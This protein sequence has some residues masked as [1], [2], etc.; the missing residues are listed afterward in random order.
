MKRSKDC[1][2]SVEYILLFALY[3]MQYCIMVANRGL[4]DTIVSYIKR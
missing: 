1:S 4:N 2:G 3:A